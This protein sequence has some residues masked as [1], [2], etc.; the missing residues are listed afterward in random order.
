MI[1]FLGTVNDYNS[2]FSYKCIKATFDPVIT[3]KRLEFDS[4][5]ETCGEITLDLVVYT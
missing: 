4:Y 3:E 1:V 2:I 5:N